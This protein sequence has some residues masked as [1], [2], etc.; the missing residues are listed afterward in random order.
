[1]KLWIDDIRTPP[2]EEWIW[3]KTSQDAI[4]VLK[5]NRVKE[6][7]FDHDLGSEENGTGYDVARWI[8]IEA[9]LGNMKC[10]KW[11]IHSANPVGRSNIEAAMKNANKYWNR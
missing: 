5:W 10:I 11:Y 2:S 4:N 7:S 3:S 1:M 6:I 9:F 8:E